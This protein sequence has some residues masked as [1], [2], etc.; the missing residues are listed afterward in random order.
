MDILQDNL[1][2]IYPR[3]LF[4]ALGSAIIMSIY[5]LVD[6]IMVGQ[7][8]GPF[9]ASAL[10]V[11]TPM[12]TIIFSLGLLF[13]IGG[14][15]RMSIE[16]G[17][18]N[19][20]EGNRYFT[21]SLLI[22]AAVSMVVWVLLFV[23]SAPLLRF[24]GGKGETLVLAEKYFFYIRL[25]LPLF[26]FGQFLSCFVRNDGNPV[27]ATAAV[28]VGGVWNMLGD[29]LLVFVADLGIEG[30]AIATITGQALS[31]LVLCSHF[32]MRRRK[33]ALVRPQE[34]ARA[35]GQV[36]YAGL[37]SFAADFSAGVLCI[38]FNNRIM[39]YLGEN[40]LAVYGVLVNIFFLVQS[41]AYGI[42]QAAQP[43]ISTNFGGGQMDRVKQTL[44]MSIFVTF[45]LGSAGLIISEL[46]PIPLVRAF[47]DSTPEVEAIAPKIMRIY[48]L[49]FLFM[50]FNVFALYYFQSVMHSS[51]AWIVAFVRGIVLSG[52]LV[53]TLPVLFGGNA[54]WWSMLITELLIFTVNLTLVL[55]YTSHEKSTVP[56][57]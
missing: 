36:F 2:K 42:G 27:L 4:S 10:A 25:G 7:Y 47:M 20:R 48:C 53:F 52:I 26:T 54:L 55:I 22:C 3:F 9:G 50:P 23:F 16:R 28:L 38:L 8:E 5:S 46:V 18:G 32:F 6:A 24:F 33:L 30:A 34:F 39:H 41:L 56:I 21:V 35:A 15:V 43:I 17:K 19:E 14:A 12:Y 45:I 51:S 29:Y 37:A 1:K 49:C 40:A 44:K 31:L 13:G 57:K 11:V